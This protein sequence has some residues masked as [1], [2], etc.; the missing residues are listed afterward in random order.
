MLSN[1]SIQVRADLMANTSLLAVLTRR[2]DGIRP[3]MAEAEDGDSFTTYFLSYQGFESKDNAAGYQLM[4]QSWAKDYDTSLA[5]A[6]QVT[7]ALSNSENHY[8]YLSA[9]PKYNEQQEIYTQQI[10]EIKQ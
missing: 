3:L 5:I 2:E 7:A 9:E 1:L 8:N 6:D 10:F 4:I